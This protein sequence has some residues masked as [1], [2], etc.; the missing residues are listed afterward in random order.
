MAEL[1]CDGRMDRS[2]SSLSC[3]SRSDSSGSTPVE[4]NL[5]SDGSG[6]R[7]PHSPPELKNDV[8]DSDDD[9]VQKYF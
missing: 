9:F 8:C 4:D 3:W 6:D 2:S 1:S 5:S 7:P